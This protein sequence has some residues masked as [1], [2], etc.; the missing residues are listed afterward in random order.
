MK[1]SKWGNSLAIR[2]PVEVAEQAGLKEGD[3]ATLFLTPDKVIEIRRDER[4]AEA[5]RLLR[6]NQFSVPHHYKFDRNEIYDS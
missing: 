1:V 4:R 2:I 3:E 6:E 5:I